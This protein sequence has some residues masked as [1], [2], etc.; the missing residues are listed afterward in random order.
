M[1]KILLFM[2]AMVT[3]IT[4]AFAED[5]TVQ[6]SANTDWTDGASGLTYTQD[7][8]TVS[9]AKAGGGTAPSVNASTNDAR[10]YAKNEVKVSTTDD[11]MTKV[12]FTVSKK[13]KYRLAP[14][15]A[16]TGEVV[17]DNTAWTVTWTGSAKEVVFTVGEKAEYGTDGATKAGQLCFDNLLIST[18]G[19]GTVDPDPEEPELDNVFSEPFNTSLGDFIIDNKTLSDGL[20]TVWSWGGANYGAQATA[21]VNKVTYASEAWL[22]SPV[23]DLTHATNSVLTFQHAAN[24]FKSFDNYKAACSVK[25]IAEGGQWTDLAYEGEPTGSSWSFVDATADLKAYDG[26]KIQ[27][28]FCYTSTADLA[29]TWEVKNFLVQAELSV[30]PIVVTP[31][32]FSPEA[33][34]YMDEV[35]VTL[36]AEEGHKIYYTLDGTEP[37]ASSTLYTEPFKL[38]ATT[39]VIAVAA[40]A[41]GNLSVNAVADYKIKESPKAPENGALFNFNANPWD[42]PV[43]TNDESFPVNGPIVEGDVT[44][45]A[46]DGSVAT[47][48]WDDYN[49]GLQLRVYKSGGSLTFTA[50]GDCKILKVEFNYSKFDMT[51][52]SGELN[53][54]VWTGEAPSVTFTANGT[55]NMNYIIVTLDKSTGIDQVEN[56]ENVEKVIYSIDGRRLQKAVKG[57]NIINGKKVLVK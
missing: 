38:T 27:V 40:D 35:T 12:V 11:A 21:Y 46:T 23:I 53:E 20:E 9:M 1:K 39:K 22:I 6:W 15:T 10:A 54:G 14:V 26:K 30:A 28:A 13:G 32:T 25:V 31:P 29:G 56:G 7:P 52:D 24:F 33:G 5:V 16:S 47:R 41:E 50:A 2:F 48:M 49:N 3:A 8:Y 37:D 51:P 17:I 34:T 19:G 18:T 45:T 4:S 55:S 43:S 36:T 42:L 44:L 57:I